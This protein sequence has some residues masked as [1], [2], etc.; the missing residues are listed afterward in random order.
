MAVT[1]EDV[2]AISGLVGRFEN[3]GGDAYQGVTGDFDGQGISCGVL[4]W[5]IGQGSLQPLVMEAG[6]ATVRAAMPTFGQDMWQACQKPIPVGLTIVRGWMNGAG[7][8]ATPKAELRQLMGTSAM[9]AAQT[10][11]IR[12]V[13]ETADGLASTWATQRG[14]GPRTK[15]ELAL[16]FDFVTQ[17]G[18]M[19]G[20]GYADVAAFKAATTPGKVDDM[21]CDWLA[22]LNASFWGYKDARKN[23]ALWR[24]NVS[25]AN[26]DL[27]VLS[28][29]RAQKSRVKA[30]GDVVNR[31]GTISTLKG[32]VHGELYDLSDLF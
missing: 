1:D 10:K 2:A 13:A 27:L 30:R 9:R 21:V 4:Q 8:K 23:G 11:R 19:S 5:N 24:N 3:G 28:Y 18:G 14:G 6:E 26:L 16:F 12:K 17:N 15:Q 7:L 25:G 31:K 32:N 20:V 29:L 22:G